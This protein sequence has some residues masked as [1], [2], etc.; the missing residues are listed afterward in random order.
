ME[1]QECFH[2]TVDVTLEH[3]EYVQANAKATNDRVALEHWWCCNGTVT[4]Q[5]E[6]MAKRA[7][8]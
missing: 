4:P 1:Y 2:E 8:I 3:L 6:H 5:P 7:I